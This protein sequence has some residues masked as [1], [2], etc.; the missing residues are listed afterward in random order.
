MNDVLVLKGHLE[1]K[2]W[3]GTISH[4]NLP[5]GK[6]VD[7]DKIRRII[8]E[9][10]SVLLFWQ[11]DKF[12]IEP[13]VSVEYISVVAKSNRI[14]RLF[15]CGKESLN[16]HIV[17]AFFSDVP[18]LH[19]I[20]TYALPI[21]AIQKGI[22]LLESVLEIVL[23]EFDGII[24]HDTLDKV[25]T[26]R[27]SIGRKIP[28]TVFSNI[29]KDVYYSGRFYIKTPDKQNIEHD[30]LVS[31]YRTGLNGNELQR[32]LGLENERIRKADENTW[33]LSP[34]QYRAVYDRA[35][36]LISMEIKDLNAVSPEEIG[37]ALRIGFSI[38]RPGNES[39]IG[40]IDTLFDTSVYFSEWV[41]YH[42]ALDEAIIERSDYVHGT[43]VSS[44]IVDGPTLNPD[45]DDGCGR[46]RVRHFG[47]SKAGKFS[48]LDIIQAI[49]EIV[50]ANKDIKVWNLSLG[51]DREIGENSV[52]PEAAV[53]DRLQWENDVIFVVAGTNNSKGDDTYPFIGSPA[54][55]INSMVVNS[56]SY[57][58]NKPVSYSRRGPV[59]RFFNKPDV[60]TFGGTRYEPISV[61]GPYGKAKKSGTSFAAPWI[62]RKLAYLI[63]VMKLPREAAK[64]LIID[65]AAAWNTDIKLLPL[66]GYGRVPTKINDIIKTKNDEIRFIINGVISSYETY[67]FNIPVPKR[68]GK[69]PYIARLTLCYFPCCN[70]NQ[71]V[72]YTDTELDVHFGRVVNGD[73]KPIDKNIQGL[74]VFADIPE[75]DVRANYRK[76]DNIKHISEKLKEASRPRK[77]YE[78]SSFWGLK[79]LSKERLDEKHVRGMHFSAVV[80]LHDIEGGNMIETF[81]KSC[82]ASNWFVERLD[83]RVMAEIY[84]EA[85][86]VIE[87]E[88]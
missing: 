21:D 75:E 33:L 39:V 76:W 87:F 46:F 24:T 47:I 71:G 53:L 20:I 82:I 74:P 48:S 34:L 11:N 42:C 69:Y 29:L 26:G 49:E 5:K 68:G 61:Y 17:G 15:Q 78:D 25:N 44:L 2:S 54:D 51:S 73:V 3:S 86:A 62:A 88:Q 57:S 36:Y 40:V 72:D 4:S 27:I 1:G 50:T 59:L 45:L 35:P 70:R 85:E 37:S 23:T 77:V 8:D 12:G 31:L 32:R 38:P 9:L 60:S 80:T 7:S 22:G 83:Q 84:Q 63:H 18:R 28:K 10:K 55:S 43:E 41:D 52:S 19:H 58:E 56:I 65:S 13:L 64:A 30:S 67:A 16:E 14:S 66:I 81:I 6:A 79:I